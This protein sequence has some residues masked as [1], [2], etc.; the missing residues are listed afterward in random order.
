VFKFLTRMFARKPLP[1]MLAKRKEIET[2]GD[3]GCVTLEAG[4][5]AGV[6]M[7]KGEET[8]PLDRPACTGF[9]GYDK[10]YT[11]E[12]LAD[13][14]DRLKVE[15]ARTTGRVPTLLILSNVFLHDSMHLLPIEKEPLPCGGWALK[16]SVLYGLKVI[17]S[18]HMKPK[19]GFIVVG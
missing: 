6:L 5:P 13:E 7:P 1:P 8:Q 2:G 19:P 17:V 10:V 11:K 9:S 15:F 3:F 4:S 16:D 18:I 14:I 12:T